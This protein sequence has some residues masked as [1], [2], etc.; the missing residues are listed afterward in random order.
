MVGSVG[1]GSD[2]VFSHC[3]VESWNVPYDDYYGKHTLPRS[4]PLQLAC[5]SA[6][7]G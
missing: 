7:S 1:L 3:L 2:G 5:T 6:R 4:A